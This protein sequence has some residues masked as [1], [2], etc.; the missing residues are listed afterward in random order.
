MS[1]F[2]E[3][4]PTLFGLV[5]LL[6]FSAYFSGS[7]TALFSL[8]RAEVKR[9]SDGSRG[10]RT[11][12]ELLRAP[13]RLLSTLLVGNMSVNILLTSVTATLIA[14]L[15]PGN[16]TMATIVSIAVS[17][18][19]LMVFGELTPKT[20][21]Y[22]HPRPVARL[23]AP[24]LAFFS[25]LFIPVRLVLHWVTSGIL[26]LIGQRHTPGWGM[27]T[28]EELA[29][30]LAVGQTTGATYEQE[31]ELVE[32]ILKLGTIDAHEIM[33]PRTELAGLDDRL[34]VQEA[35]E[36]AC[37]ERHSRMPVYSRGLDDIWGILS[38]IDYPRWR[39]SAFLNEP[40]AS[41]RQRV[42]DNSTGELLPV[43]PVYVFP[44]NAKLERILTEMRGHRAQMA[45]LVGEYGGTAG[46]LTLADIIAE[47]IGRFSRRDSARDFVD[48]GQEV[49]AG[50][51]V[52]IRSLNEELGLTLTA[53]GADTLG[54]Y[55]LERLERIPRAGD[56]VEDDGHRFTVIKMA[57]RRVDAIRIERLAPPE[58]PVSDGRAVE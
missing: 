17:T 38:V 47:I 14:R 48:T 49:L 25:V 3:L 30:T 29:A 34:T 23:A 27:L 56:T 10:E 50:G 7:E 37:R 32:K 33:V 9:M 28:Q 13:Q 45:V 22:G 21:A 40:L 15:V 4:L 58:V 2:L 39:E 43:Y 31:R 35:Y 8:N 41:L 52:L 44:E 12:S 18:P 53:N 6:G 55:V 36:I 26:A 46:I 51:R 11:A 19:L 24:G 16:E 5:V 1:E 20:I 42:A 54:G 57:G